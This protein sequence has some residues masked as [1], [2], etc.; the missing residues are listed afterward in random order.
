MA[1]C[2]E[3]ESDAEP[4][5]AALV[6]V[7]A[8]AA[9]EPGADAFAAFRPADLDCEQP[10]YVLEPLG[11]ELALELD[12]RACAHITVAQPTLLDLDEGDSILLRL[13][14]FELTAPDPALAHLGLA[15]DGTVVWEKEVPIPTASALVLERIPVTAPLPPGS[16]L[17]FHV[18][19]HGFNTYSLLEISRER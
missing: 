14:H 3:P 4:E 16:A 18:R 11:S 19:N 17:Q 1:G 5:L 15:L 7:R 9:V 10:G 2:A 6:D 12:T 8:F 13:F